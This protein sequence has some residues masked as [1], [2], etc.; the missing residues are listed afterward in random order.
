M[1]ITLIIICSNKTA[2]FKGHNNA[3]MSHFL[4]QKFCCDIEVKNHK[5]SPAEPFTKFHSI[6]THFHV[7]IP[8]KE[9]F[10]IQDTCRK[11]GWCLIRLTF[12]CQHMTTS[13]PQA[14]WLTTMHKFHC[15][16]MVKKTCPTTYFSVSN[17]KPHT[18]GLDVP[19]RKG[20]CWCWENL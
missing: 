10:F 8:C 18:E 14:R 19:L 16:S 20:D 15:V 2:L 9:S 6:K 13:C 1:W 11:N 12:F 3:W 17:I 7:S 5:N 4:S